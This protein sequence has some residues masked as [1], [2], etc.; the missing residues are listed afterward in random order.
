VVDPATLP[1]KL[2][3]Y[4]PLALEVARQGITLLA[5]QNKALPIGSFAHK[6]VV[7]VGSL[8][9]DEAAHVGGYTN[10]G[11]AVTTVWA[12]IQKECSAA[13]ECHAV[14]AKGASPDSFET[15]GIAAA[16]AA[17]AEADIVVAVVGDS[18]N[19]AGE[20][21]DVDDLDLNGAQLP[22]LWAVIEAVRK[23]TKLL[24]VIISAQPKTFG[25]SLWTPAG[26]GK[27]NALLGSV[28]ALLA[29][30]RP[31][32]EGGTAVL[33]IITGRYNPSGRLSHT[34]PAKAGQVH[35]VVAN[36]YH[37][38]ATHAGESSAFTTGPAKPLFPFGYG[39]SFSA[40]S[41]GKPEVN[42]PQGHT[43]NCTQRFTLTVPVSSQG[44]RGTVT[45]QV[46]AAP[47]FPTK[48][49]YLASRLLCWTQI[50]VPGNGNATATISCAASD[51]AMWDLAVG[52]YLV[53][54]GV[55]RLTVA[56]FA[57]DPNAATATVDV[58]ATPIP[59]PEDAMRA[60]AVQYAATH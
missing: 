58:T 30:W 47:T 9:D 33:D 53:E 42:P 49:A 44:P 6:K 19:T 8:A 15:D 18:E 51:L 16:V 38:G 13:A 17:V 23:D 50:I 29:A 35:S 32:E 54:G 11:A 52:D 45:L 41:V 39:L 28:D 31:G 48:Q 22:L 37:L 21:H 24:A 59:K 34:W 14:L 36:S 25:A 26:V 4:R 2:D 1:A 10:G 46:Y 55:Y 40:F 56:Q 57:G 60:R 3:T 20:N 27:P 7:V 43:A 5:N 12:A